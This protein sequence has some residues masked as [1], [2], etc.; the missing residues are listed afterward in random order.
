MALDLLRSTP[1]KPY[2]AIKLLGDLGET[3]EAIRL[4]E[5]FARNGIASTSFL[6]TGDACR[7]AGRLEEAAK[8]YRKAID[9]IP[10]EEA[11]KPHRK[12]DRARAEANLAAIRFH[13]LDPG[14]VRDGTYRSSSVGYEGPVE[15]E[16]EVKS[17]RIKDVRIIR[18]REKQYYS[19]LSDTPEKILS[20]Q[21][22][23]EIDAT[24]SATI[25]SEAIIN[26]T[27]KAL[28]QGLQ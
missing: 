1:R 24:S 2:S 17:G 13:S 22:V 15:V 23:A 5:S 4:G 20:H 19:S 3:N 7:V 16:V 18:H 28:S 10:T 21:S 14:K 26:A 12:R 11:D 6:Y 27:A 9:G 8:Y 25:T